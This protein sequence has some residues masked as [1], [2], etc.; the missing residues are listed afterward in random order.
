MPP[1]RAL[2]EG[3]SASPAILAPTSLRALSAAVWRHNVAAGQ[4]GKNN[5]FQPDGEA[6]GSAVECIMLPG[7][8]TNDSDPLATARPRLL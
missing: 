6:N 8:R 4:A 1:H 3:S 5:D 7:V 2:P